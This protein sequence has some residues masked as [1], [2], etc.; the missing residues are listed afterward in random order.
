MEKQQDWTPNLNEDQARKLLKQHSELRAKLRAKLEREPNKEELYKTLCVAKT[1]ALHEKVSE[2]GL[3][4]DSV[5]AKALRIWRMQCILQRQ[6]GGVTVSA[7]ADEWAAQSGEP[8]P[9]VPLEAPTEAPQPK[10]YSLK[11][12][13]FPNLESLAFAAV[14]RL[15]ELLREHEKSGNQY[16]RFYLNG[17]TNLEDQWYATKKKPPERTPPPATGKSKKA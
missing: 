16:V 5:D 11:K 2:G 4:D 15:V 12:T 13:L 9:E 17:M 3:W 14:Q 10:K 7:T 8:M 1:G 6:I